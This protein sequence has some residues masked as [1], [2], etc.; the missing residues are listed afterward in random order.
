[1][2]AHRCKRWGDR[3]EHCVF[4]RAS[5]HTQDQLDEGDTWDDDFDNEHPVRTNVPAWTLLGAAVY[6]SLLDSYG[7]KPLPAF[8]PVF[9]PQSARL[10]NA[11]VGLAEIGIVRQL[12]LPKPIQPPTSEE[13]KLGKSYAQYWEY[14]ETFAWVIGTAAAIGVAGLVG[15]GPKGRAQGK[16]GRSGMGTPGV[17]YSFSMRNNPAF[18]FMY[19]ANPLRSLTS[20]VY[21]QLVGGYVPMGTE[22]V[23]E[24]KTREAA[25]GDF[26]VG[27]AFAHGLTGY[28]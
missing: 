23:K 11:A 12:E 18:A 25:V 8:D 22:V 2:R 16:F 20:D 7:P 21:G 13:P 6:K 10:F 27:S 5:W 28:I 19:S 14:G 3:R 1:V 9:V 15:G 24:T 17:G 26:G 4:S